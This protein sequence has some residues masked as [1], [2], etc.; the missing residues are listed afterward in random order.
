MSS[1]RQ[2]LLAD[3]GVPAGL[4]SDCRFAL[5]NRTNRGPVYLRC[6][7]ATQRPEFAKYPRLPVLRCSGHLRV[8]PDHLAG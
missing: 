7:L 5:L 4:C 8:Q 1:D 6:G 3:L 2:Q